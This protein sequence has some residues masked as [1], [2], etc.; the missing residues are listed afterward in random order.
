MV[1]MNYWLGRKYAN[2]E[3]ATEA[4]R[5]S[6]MA[7]TIKANAEAAQAASLGGLRK[8]QATGLNLENQ[9]AEAYLP[10]DLDVAQDL[11]ST[12]R[13]AR[14]D[15]GA[16]IAGG[17]DMQTPDQ[18]GAARR[19]RLSE[20]VMGRKRGATK[21]IDKTGNGNPKKDTVPA[22]LAEGE[23]VLNAGAAEIMGRSEIA[24]LNK[25]GLRAM[26]MSETSAP[27]MKKN[28]RLGAYK[29]VSMVPRMQYMEGTEYATADMEDDRLSTDAMGGGLR[30][31][32]AEGTERVSLLD[33][34]KNAAGAFRGANV[35]PAAPVAAAPLATPAPAAPVAP[36]GVA[37][38]PIDDY[39][40][41][42]AMAANQARSIMAGTGPSAPV[43]MFPET[44]PASPASLRPAASMPQLTPGSPMMSGATPGPGVG[45]NTPQVTDRFRAPSP[46]AAGG[47]V[48]PAAP[49]SAPAAAPAGAPG[50]GVLNTIKNVGGNVLR[51]AGMVAKGSIPVAAGA[52]AV[53]LYRQ[54]MEA[55]TGQGYGDLAEQMT[56]GTLPQQP[57]RSTPVSLREGRKVQATTDAKAQDVDRQKDSDR[58]LTAYTDAYGKAM[59]DNRVRGMLGISA[60]SGNKNAQELLSEVGKRDAALASSIKGDKDTFDWFKQLGKDSFSTVDKNGNMVADKIS[61]DAFQRFVLDDLSKNNV[62]ISKMSAQEKIT[63]ERELRE[64]FDDLSRANQISQERGGRVNFR[65]GV[66][67]VGVVDDLS[68]AG[69]MG[70][71]YTLWQGMR[72]WNNKGVVLRDAQ[73]NEQTVALSDYTRAT[74]DPG[75]RDPRRQA[76]VKS[77]ED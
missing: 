70:Q 77:L 74:S 52:A 18:W 7:Q 35:A 15:L 29:G 14:Y 60:W 30:Q 66:T 57:V 38:N 49:P 3:N 68:M 45:V 31:G 76:Q 26:N 11:R 63:A 24:S 19:Y 72:P 73:G 65:G 10:L 4:Q 23:A 67:P 25:K 56:V 51:G 39:A 1:N 69:S 40:A 50:G 27:A 12:P 48:P 33:R 2:L 62:N 13:Q 37:S 75:L 34:F 44:R 32:Y 59:R 46:S 16:R 71:P 61:E 36:V 21:I 55:D 54:G 9:R 64:R 17:V 47:Q 42:R 28:G 8:S 5:E 20:S 41:R 43:D 53:D 6:A 22:M 58:E